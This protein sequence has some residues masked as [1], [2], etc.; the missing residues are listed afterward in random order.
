MWN[1]WDGEDIKN[2]EAASQGKPSISQHG[3]KMK[4][5]N[6]KTY[7]ERGKRGQKQR[8]QLSMC[9][10]YWTTKSNSLLSRILQNCTVTWIK[11]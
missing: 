5:S 2:I 10:F 11:T 4:Q 9:P 7:I 6:I 1:L 3:N 8:T